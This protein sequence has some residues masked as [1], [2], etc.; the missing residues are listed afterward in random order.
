MTSDELYKDLPV[1]LL[2]RLG[3]QRNW[4]ELGDDQKLL[5]EAAMSVH[6]RE[7]AELKAELEAAEAQ[8]HHFSGCR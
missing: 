2:E 6:E 5:V 3:W 7:I 1:N 4:I 8:I